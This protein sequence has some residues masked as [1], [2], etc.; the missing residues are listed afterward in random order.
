MLT[1]RVESIACSAQTIDDSFG[2]LIASSKQS[3]SM[4][5]AAACGYLSVSVFL[6]VGPTNQR[7]LRP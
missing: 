1:L 5:T 7:P 3:K 4:T 2:R 6:A